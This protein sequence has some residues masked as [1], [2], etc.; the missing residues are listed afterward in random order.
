MERLCLIGDSGTGT[1]T[2]LIPIG[3]GAAQQGRCSA[4]T[5]TVAGLLVITGLAVAAA[6]RIEEAT[7]RARAEQLAG[8]FAALGCCRPA[9]LDALSQGRLADEWLLRDPA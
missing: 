5:S 1:S 2:L 6:E 7:E 3:I 8:D 9:Q 4:G